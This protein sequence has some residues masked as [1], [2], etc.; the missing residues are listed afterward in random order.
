M[1]LLLPEDAK[2]STSVEDKIHLPRFAEEIARSVA[3][4]KRRM[5][6]DG[7]LYRKCSTPEMD[8][9]MISIEQRRRPESRAVAQ[10]KVCG[11]VNRVSK[12]IHCPHCYS[13]LHSDAKG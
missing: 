6:P 9:M 3:E 8:Q 1:R 13:P 7:D 11:H 5:S 10:C 2:V 12:S 4:A